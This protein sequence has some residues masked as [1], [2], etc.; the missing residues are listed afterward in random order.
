MKKYT[1]F[2][3]NR[4]KN[5]KQRRKTKKQK[6]KKQMYWKGGGE[7]HWQELEQSSIQR[8]LCSQKI[9]LNRHLD[10]LQLCPNKEKRGY[11]WSDSS[12]VQSN[13]AADF[14]CL[15][16]SCV[17]LN[18]ARSYFGGR[19]KCRLISRTVTG[20]QAWRFVF[21]NRSLKIFMR[22]SLSL[23]TCLCATVHFSSSQWTQKPFNVIT[24]VN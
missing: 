22:A 14:L 17:V 7:R 10:L 5:I 18:L 21:E 2:Q 8:K 20:N 11:C 1:S 4:N 13:S 3:W 24:E 6:Q 15:I 12:H 16:G 9:N 23:H 19:E